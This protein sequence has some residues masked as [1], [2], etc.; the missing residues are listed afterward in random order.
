MEWSKGGCAGLHEGLLLL[1]GKATEAIEALAL[2]ITVVEA[3]VRAGREL[4]KVA[5][6]VV[7]VDLGDGN[8]SRT[9]R[10]D[11]VGTSTCGSEVDF[12][13]VL[14][15][16]LAGLVA[17]GDLEVDG[18]SG[19]G[20]GGRVRKLAEVGGALGVLVVTVGGLRVGGDVLYTIVEAV[21]GLHRAS[22]GGNTDVGE[23]AVGEGLERVLDR[24]SNDGIAGGGTRVYEI[25]GVGD[26]DTAIS[27]VEAQEELIA[28]GGARNLDDLLLSGGLDGGE[29]VVATGNLAG[30][31]VS[32]VV[33]KVALAALDLASIPELVEVAGMLVGVGSASGHSGGDETAIP[34]LLPAP[35]AGSESS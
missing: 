4:G 33:A 17:H 28:G 27:I 26:P 35:V 13:K 30:G 24:S 7:V 3:T 9:T 23:H 21:A 6:V 29:R 22:V 16:S 32:T 20:Q 10:G 8:A 14:N 25:D 19:G 15:T 34:Q 18:G 12:E 5:E 31:A 2:A 1:A 11:G